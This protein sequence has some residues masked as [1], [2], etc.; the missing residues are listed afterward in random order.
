MVA[1]GIASFTESLS[2][3]PALIQVITGL[4]AGLAARSFVTAIGSI[5][6][7]FAKIPFGLGIPLA[8]GAIA[9]MRTEA[10]GART[11]AQ[12]KEGMFTNDLNPGPGGTPVN[13]HA[14]EVITPID[15]LGKFISDAMK[16]VVEENRRM[17]EQN[18]TLITETRKIGT[19]TADAIGAME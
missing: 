9:M 10:S 5:F 11:M 17:R 4:L 16:P 14:N 6:T 2:K 8:L 18:E 7:T 1:G 13:V 12:A 19:R 15:K 3:S